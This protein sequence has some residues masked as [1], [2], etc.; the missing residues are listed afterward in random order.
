[1][2][3]SEFDYKFP[4]DLIAK[5]P[6]PER[7]ASRMMVVDRISQEISHNKIAD[8]PKFLRK[9]DLVVINKTR[10][11]PARLIGKRETGGRVEILLLKP[12]PSLCSS[13]AAQWR[14]I[15]DRTA[16]LKMGSKI[17]F[18][19][20]LEAKILAR[21][22]EVLEIEFNKPELIENAGLPPL[23]PYILAARAKDLT[24]NHKPSTINSDKE[25]YQTIFAKNLGSAAAPTASLH[26]SEK[27]LNEIKNSGAE[28]APIT[29]HVGL[30]TFSPVRTENIEDH[31]IHGEEYSISKESSEM[32]LKANKEG[33]RIIAVGTTCVR[34]LESAIDHDF[35]NHEPL[36]T[37]HYIYPGYK[38]KIVSAMLT[39]FHQPKSTLLM[40]VSAF[41]GK[42]F[43]FKAYQEAI[44]EKYRL[45]S[46]GDC[47]LIL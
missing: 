17:Y 15:S 31:R 4:E 2:K 29:L 27:L 24:I 47:M 20:G 28:I 46:Y 38:F 34:A 45:F 7:D 43:I 6:L 41:A 13:T 22:G 25:R 37:N 5:H 18:E 9:G 36:I 1:M 12:V 32:I 8:L 3:L 11:F 44:R 39:N 35:T 26:F 33:C 10:V 23:P 21:I 40:L 42:E 16:K 30:D 19:N 14:C